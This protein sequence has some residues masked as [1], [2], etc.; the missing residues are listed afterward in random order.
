M[1]RRKQKQHAKLCIFMI[2]W[3]IWL[4]IR[5]CHKAAL[6]KSRCRSRFQASGDIRTCSYT[7]LALCL[8]DNSSGLFLKIQ[9]LGK[10][11]SSA[12]GSHAEVMLSA[13][14]LDL[15]SPVTSGN[16]SR[17]HRVVRHTHTGLLMSME[18]EQAAC[19]LK[20]IEVHTACRASCCQYGS[21]WRPLALHCITFH[22]NQ[23]E[24]HKSDF[25]I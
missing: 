6:K 21:V 12:K 5:Y 1:T 4:L 20:L 2:I 11:I 14:Y 16:C 17:Y 10:L 8:E 18:G 7:H 23:K 9:S 19:T 13:P 25:I 22:L 15:P 3:F 24:C